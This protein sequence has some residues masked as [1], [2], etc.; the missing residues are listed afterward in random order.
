MHNLF[1]IKLQIPLEVSK[2]QQI[3]QHSSLIVRLF[4]WLNQSML[5]GQ[6]LWILHT[7]WLKRI[8]HESLLCSSRWSMWKITLHKKHY[9]NAASGNKDQIWITFLTLNQLEIIVALSQRK[10]NAKHVA[11]HCNSQ[12]LI[13]KICFSSIFDIYHSTHFR[14]S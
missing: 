13:F 11:K 6:L 14:K 3:T 9:D 8:K 4:E 10:I 7:H 2:A 12:T 5:I 1:L